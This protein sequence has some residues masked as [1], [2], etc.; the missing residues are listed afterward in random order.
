MTYINIL[1]NQLATAWNQNLRKRIVYLLINLKFETAKCNNKNDKIIKNHKNTLFIESFRVNKY[2]GIC[3]NKFCKIRDDE[4]VPNMILLSD[5]ASGKTRLLQALFWGTANISVI[6]R[7]LKDDNFPI[8]F[9]PYEAKIEIKFYDKDPTLITKFYWSPFEMKHN[10]K[11]KRYWSDSSYL[12][13]DD[14]Q[15]S[16]LALGSNRFAPLS[17][18]ND[19][20]SNN[21]DSP[22]ERRLRFVVDCTKTLFIRGRGLPDYMADMFNDLPDIEFRSDI[23]ESSS[24]LQ[25]KLSTDDFFSWLFSYLLPEIQPSKNKDSISRIHVKYNREKK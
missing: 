15:L 23:D 14:E 19:K 18:E 20:N 24:S 1:L 2:R 21:S 6:G 13:Y 16:I 8:R 4:P 3:M 9:K 11:F 17:T 10:Y 25:P 7:L 22:L 12:S 5:N